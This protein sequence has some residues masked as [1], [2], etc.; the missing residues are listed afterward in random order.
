MDFTDQGLVVSDLRG[1]F[2]VVTPSNIEPLL[3]RAATP[4]VDHAEVERVLQQASLSELDAMMSEPGEAPY[5]PQHLASTFRVDVVGRGSMSSWAPRLKAA[6]EEQVLWHGESF[7]PLS[8]WSPPRV[9]HAWCT[10]AQHEFDRWRVAVSDLH[11]IYCVLRDF[12]SGTLP[13]NAEPADDY[14]K[15]VARTATW[16]QVRRVARKSASTAAAGSYRACLA[17]LP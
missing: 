6:V 7:S 12:E 9:R 3:E 2:I 11:H 1:G 5:I 10:A 17:R 14:A 8:E 13:S 16:A 4:E 15:M